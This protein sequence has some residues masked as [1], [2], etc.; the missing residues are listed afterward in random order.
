[1]N[2][3]ILDCHPF[4][5]GRIRRHISYLVNNS[6][7]VF[8]IH[9]NRYNEELNEGVFSIFGEKSFRINVFPTLEEGKFRTILFLFFSLFWT[10]MHFK[11]TRNFL[12][13]MKISKKPLI[14]H[15]HDPYLLPFAIYIKNNT[16]K[17][18][19]IVY[20]RHEIHEKMDI[21]FGISIPHFFEKVSNKNISGIVTI[22]DNKSHKKTLENIFLTDNIIIVPNYPL[23]SNVDHKLVQ[24][25]INNFNKYSI[26]NM[27]YIGSLDGKL[28]R[29]IELILDLADEILSNYKLV[30]FFLG[31]NCKDPKMLIKINNL[32]KKY[33]DN[34]TFGGLIP[35]EEVIKYTLDSHMGFF[36]L[37]ENSDYWV[38]CSPNKIF[39]YLICGVIPIVKADLDNKEELSSGIIFFNRYSNKAEIYASIVG[40]L[41]NPEHLKNLM[42][43]AYQKGLSHSWESVAVRYLEFYD[44]LLS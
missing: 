21:F 32:V 31:G 26:I 16:L 34:F 7:S 8:R 30:H 19:K 14:I 38:T 3:L 39:E 36:L 12:K 6:C 1:M 43:Y 4:N 44:F 13:S 17:N 41:E 42:T 40:L 10:N 18:S 27:I 29:D 5:D 22:L 15:V 20:D 35:N 28:D 24:N 25:K 2:I 11:K 37:K 33:P 9:I 23:Q